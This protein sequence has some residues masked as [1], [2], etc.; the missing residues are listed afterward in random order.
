MRTFKSSDDEKHLYFMIE[1]L[2]GE[3]IFLEVANKLHAEQDIALL[4]R[5]KT[6]YVLAQK[7]VWKEQEF[8]L[9][10]DMDFG[11]TSLYSESAECLKHLEEILND[12]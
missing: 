5:E 12:E 9:T 1:S 7:G 3:E 4:D 2:E 11:N 10:Y 8:E 6:I